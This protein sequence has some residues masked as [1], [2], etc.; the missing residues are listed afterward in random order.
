MTRA[1][2]RQRR[3]FLRLLGSVLARATV[4][5]VLLGVALVLSAAGTAAPACTIVGTSGNDTLTGTSGNDVICGLGGNDTINGLGGADYLTGGDGVDTFVADASADGADKMIGGGGIDTATYA[6]RTT[7]V[8]VTI[9]GSAN[10]GAPGEGDDVGVDVENLVGGSGDDSLAG[11]AAQNALTGGTGND[12]LSG[13]A[14]DDSLAGEDGDDTLDGGADVDI[15]QGGPGANVVSSCEADGTDTTP[16]AAVSGFTAT[17]LGNR[18]DLAWTNPPDSDLRDVTLVRKPGLV[19][20]G[21]PKDGTVVALVAPPG[22]SFSDPNL[23][24]CYSYTA[25]SR[26]FSG[27]YGLGRKSSGETT[28]SVAVAGICG[29]VSFDRTLA[30]GV[31]SVYVLDSLTV[32]AGV[33]L[34]VP[35]GVVAKVESPAVVVRGTLRAVGT[36]TTRAT[37]TSYFDDSIGGDTDGTALA[38]RAWTAD[39]RPGSSLSANSGDLRFLHATTPSSGSP[40]L[41]LTN[42]I[43]SDSL[44]AAQGGTAQIT[45]SSFTRTSLSTDHVAA[46]TIRTNTF[47]DMQV[48]LT[49]ENAGNLAGVG[50]NTA[51]GAPDQRVFRIQSSTVPGTWTLD[52]LANGIYELYGITVRAG[53]T[54]TVTPGAVLKN[55]PP[56][57]VSVYGTLKALGTASA[58][59]TFTHFF[60]DT[61]VGDSNGDGP[62]TPTN[63]AGIEVGQ[64]AN[65]QLGN[66][67]A[68][69]FSVH[70]TPFVPASPAATVSI[71]N[72]TL[73][74]LGATGD[75]FAATTLQYA[76]FSLTQT[77]LNQFG[78]QLVNGTATITGNTITGAQL[79]LNGQAAPTV[80]TNTF[81]DMQVPLTVENAGNLAGVG[82]NTATGTPDQRVF[83]IQSSTVPGTWT[84]D[85]LANGIYELYGITVRAGATMTV[86]PGAVL[87]N[88]PPYG[89]S[90]YGTLKALGTAS[91]PIT[92]THFFD[93]T[94]VGDSNGDGPSTPTNSAGIEVGQGANVQLGNV[95]ARFFSVH[96]TPFVPASPAATVSIS[97]STLAGLGATGDAFA[98]TTL[99]YAKFS[100]TQTHLN[101]FGAQLINGTATITGNTITGAQLHLNGQAAP[102]VR[103][104]AFSGMAIPL[105]VENVSDLAGVRSNSAG[106]SDAEHLFRF[107]T[108]TVRTTWSVPPEGTAVYDLGQVDVADGGTMTVTP[109]A[110]VKSADSLTIR[111]GGTLTA[112]GATFTSIDDDAVGGDSN[113]DGDTGPG[114]WNGIDAERGSTVTIKNSTIKYASIAVRANAAGSTA[115]Y[116]TVSLNG[117]HFV[118]NGFD[119]WNG[120][121]DL[122]LDDVVVGKAVDAKD[123][124]ARPTAVSSHTHTCVPPPSDPPLPP[125]TIVIW[126]VDIDGFND[127]ECPPLYTE[128][129]P[130]S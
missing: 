27:H 9:D 64:G 70:S 84:L 108:S 33:T 1:H 65:V 83:R 61:V 121:K 37:L 18:I 13:L 52:P 85:P 99:Q 6:N 81:A 88:Q 68:R 125:E 119:I 104:N 72:S 12:T 7:A 16:P 73:A 113:G 75:A 26:D 58:P 5:G 120:P 53:A 36:S 38:P 67:D 117:S 56:Y 8:S 69:F 76:K 114:S 82:S 112:N 77:H 100:L 94:V 96:S 128:E 78:A 17:G 101:Q 48:P 89:V 34:T 63:S 15:C 124:N 41:V 62:S 43:V 98:A 106:G 109:G 129:K 4:L 47:A 14:G 86:T 50:S 93:D 91:A 74:G 123:S 46:P 127:G 54:M 103:S 118:D 40:S 105:F 11:S 60:D 115:E 25:F 35:A 87:K 31:A 110:V 24:G 23:D 90:V 29:S 107:W 22:K 39:L 79:H 122:K 57:G 80:R 111:T 130:H 102:T 21:S 66:V 126:D 51:T 2:P 92:F 20:P 59:I 10:D 19:P 45:G 95:D 30:S 32:E 97:N 71:S 3:S 49:V 42:S 116:A 55:Q 28:S 44:I